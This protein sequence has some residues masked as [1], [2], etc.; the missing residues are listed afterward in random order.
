[1]TDLVVPAEADWEAAPRLL[2]GAGSLAL[3]VEQCNMAYWMSA[4]AQGTLLGR[5]LGYQP[6]AVTPDYM[7]R[8]G[9]LREA[10]VL[11]MTY[12]SLDEEAAVRVLTHYVAVAPDVPEMEFFSTQLIDEV[13]HHMIF[14]DHLLELGEP[15]EGLMDRIRQRGATYLTEVLHPIRDFAIRIARDEQDYIGAVVAFAIII[16]G[17]LAAS[18]ELSE[19]KWAPFSPVTTEIERGASIDEIRHLAVGSTIVRDH[20]IKH[21]EGRDHLL[22]IIQRGKDMWGTISD[23]EYVMT[24]ERL[25]QEGM[26][27]P[28][29]A[30]RLEGYEIYPGR[31]LRDTTPEERWDL[32]ATWNDELTEKRLEYMGLPEA[33]DLLRSK[34]PRIL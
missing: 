27:A 18:T 3:S 22:D 21:P 33:M 16:E 14:R 7:R 1:M 29:H 2:E 26:T 24:R 17:I 5:P 13:R 30:E 32:A 11:E 23:R 34:A 9:P 8:P 10:L 12:R 31:L 6:G 20:L 4:V 28:E 19:I 25:Y 15:Q